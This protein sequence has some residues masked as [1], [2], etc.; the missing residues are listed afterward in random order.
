[1]TCITLQIA[2]LAADSSTLVALPISNEM[3]CTHITSA[4]CS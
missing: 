2:H 4:Y 3:G 1:M